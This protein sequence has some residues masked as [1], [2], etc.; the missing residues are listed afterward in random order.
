MNV[1][2]QLWII[3]ATNN[4]KFIGTNSVIH[5]GLKHA[6]IMSGEINITD[7]L[8]AVQTIILIEDNDEVVED[9]VNY[10]NCD[11]KDVEKLLNLRQKTNHSIFS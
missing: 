9:L 1:M 11:R 3:L 4:D 2:D 7:T 6:D 5:P 10:V 8:A